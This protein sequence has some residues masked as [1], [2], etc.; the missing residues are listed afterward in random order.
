WHFFGLGVPLYACRPKKM[1]SVSLSRQSHSLSKKY[2]FDKLKSGGQCP[3]LR[4][5]NYF[6]HGCLSFSEKLRQ[7]RKTGNY[8][9]FSGAKRRLVS[10]TAVF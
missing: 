4:C 6:F 5:F 1:P 8:T 3:P 10:K 2:F 9:I 7:V